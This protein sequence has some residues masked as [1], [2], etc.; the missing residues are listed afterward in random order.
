MRNK[1]PRHPLPCPSASAILRL[2][3]FTFKTQIRLRQC[4][5]SGWLYGP[6]TKVTYAIG[7]S[8]IFFQGLL[9]LSQ[10]VSQP[11]PQSQ[12][13]F[14]LKGF[15]SPFFSLSERTAFTLPGGRLPL[16]LQH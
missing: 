6:T 11:P 12:P 13:L 2:F 3:Y 16:V 15:S 4:L 9:H 8:F 10:S 1:P 5:K 7:P 14:Q